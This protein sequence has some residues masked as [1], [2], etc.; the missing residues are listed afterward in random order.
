MQLLTP[1][2]RR[3]EKGEGR[4]LLKQGSVVKASVSGARA[5][6]NFFGGSSIYKD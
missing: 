3:L 6:L 1:Y 5:E 4:Q 2:P